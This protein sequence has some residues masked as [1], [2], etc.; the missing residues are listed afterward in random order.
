[1]WL[2][3]SSTSLPERKRRRPACYNQRECDSWSSKS[4]ETGSQLLHKFSYTRHMPCISRPET[5][6]TWCVSRDWS[7]TT[8]RRQI[9]ADA[10]PRLLQPSWW[11]NSSKGGQ[12]YCAALLYRQTCSG[13]SWADSQATNIWLCHFDPGPQSTTAGRKT[14]HG[15]QMIPWQSTPSLTWFPS[16]TR[17]TKKFHT[18][19]ALLNSQPS[20]P[21]SALSTRWDQLAKRGRSFKN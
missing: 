13:W 17:K 12:S 8:T 14:V 4:H 5:L 19:R 1:M 6:T 21:F 16:P 18:M 2:T 20:R 9:V 3:G 11:Q 7:T 10:D 15:L